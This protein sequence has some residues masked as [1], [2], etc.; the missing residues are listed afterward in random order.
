MPKKPNDACLCVVNILIEYH[1]GFCATYYGR[2]ENSAVIVVNDSDLSY[3]LMAVLGLLMEADDYV[4]EIDGV[5][6]MIPEEPI[7]A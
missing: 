2:D 7:E 4:E 3:K 5:P 6:V 1:K